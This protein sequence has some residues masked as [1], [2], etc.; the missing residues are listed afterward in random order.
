MGERST[1]ERILT[2]LLDAAGDY[3]PGQTLQR[4]LG[5]SRPAIYQ[6]V[7]RLGQQD[8]VIEAKRHSG[9]RLAREPER[10]N[11]ILLQAYR[12]LVLGCPMIHFL[13]TVDSTNSVAE[14]YVAEGRTTPFVVLSREQTAGRGRRGRVW[15]SPDEGNLYA[16]FAFRPELPPRD[17]PPITLWLGLA[18]ARS[19]RRQL[20]LP[21]MVKWPNDLLLE[22]RKLAGMLTEARIDADTMRDLVFG[23]G[24]NLRAETR[25]WPAEVRA[26][27]TAVSAHLPVEKTLSWHRLVV[28][29]LA[30]VVRAYQAYLKVPGARILQD[31]WND[32]DA[33]AG[34]TVEVQGRSGPLRGLADGIDAGGNLRLRLPD[35]AV[36]PVGSGE[37]TIGTRPVAN[38]PRGS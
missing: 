33:L 21:V 5:I 18:V 28:E 2:Q 22:G 32:Y 25:Q 1:E 16:S 27:A 3:V 19:L 38:G 10:L 11:A 20:E 7:E 12:P 6:C 17:M 15:H 14:R 30:E 37:V 4:I 9:Y 23:L 26:V 13:D 24:L 8:I 35:G 31:A 36:Y 29:I 34:Q